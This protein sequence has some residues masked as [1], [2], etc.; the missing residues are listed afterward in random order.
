MLDGQERARTHNELPLM[1]QA[2]VSAAR[3]C[4]APEVRRAVAQGPAPR[5]GPLE[6]RLGREQRDVRRSREPSHHTGRESSSGCTHAP[7]PPTGPLP[8]DPALVD[9]RSRRQ[10]FGTTIADHSIAALHAGA[11]CRQARSSRKKPEAAPSTFYR[12][13]GASSTIVPCVVVFSC[14]SPRHR[15]G[16]R[17]DA[18]RGR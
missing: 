17:L 14:F 7:N 8:V 6:R 13:S 11:R 1:P 18:P 10:A 9:H 4:C 3:S 15:V 2:G 5:A 12:V 16:A